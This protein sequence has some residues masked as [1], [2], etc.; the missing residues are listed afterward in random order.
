[1]GF[2]PASA[3]LTLNAFLTQAGRQYLVAGDKTAFDIKYFALSD[4]HINYLAAWETDVNGNYLAP[5]SGRLPDLSGDYAGDVR[6]LA[7]G[8]YLR[9]TLAGGAGISQLGTNGQLG[10][11]LNKVGFKDAEYAVTLPLSGTVTAGSSTVGVIVVTGP[12]VLINTDGGT[13]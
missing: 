13:V 2:I 11:P 9:S 1:M 12:P 8:G 6:S 3:G 4:E 10:A 7:G 5:G